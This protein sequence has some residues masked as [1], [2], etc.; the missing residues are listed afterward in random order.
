MDYRLVD[1]IIFFVGVCHE[2]LPVI[3]CIS[4]ETVPLLVLVYICYCLLYI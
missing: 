3:A 1:L 4:W 2:N